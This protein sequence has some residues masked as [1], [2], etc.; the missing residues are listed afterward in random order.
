MSGF[1]TGRGNAGWGRD[2]HGERQKAINKKGCRASRRTD[3]PTLMPG[4]IP[5]C[6]GGGG[7]WLEAQWGDG[8]AAR[9]G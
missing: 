4:T 7:G 5:R 8:G 2:Q 9:V 6:K 3:S 1:G